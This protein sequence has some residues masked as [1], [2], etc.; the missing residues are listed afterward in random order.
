LKTPK[1]LILLWDR[2]NLLDLGQEKPKPIR[3]KFLFRTKP[4]K[5]RGYK[6][7]TYTLGHS[8]VLHANEAMKQILFSYGP[9]NSDHKFE[10]KYIHTYICHLFVYLFVVYLITI[11]AARI[12][13]AEN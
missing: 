4:I 12:V 8:F 11:S 10:I 9:E 3:E 13:S 5:H 2:D 6:I 7:H 1:Q